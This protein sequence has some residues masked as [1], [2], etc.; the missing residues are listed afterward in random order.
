MFKVWKRILKF[1]KASNSKNYSSSV[2]TLKNLRLCSSK[3][4]L[5]HKSTFKIY[6][7]KGY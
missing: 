1:I 5:T 6:N 3:V 2:L 4:E 7:F